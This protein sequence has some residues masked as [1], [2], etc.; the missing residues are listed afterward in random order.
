MNGFYVTPSIARK[1]NK[2]IN[3]FVEFSMRY[4]NLTEIQNGNTGQFYTPMLSY[5]IGN[6]YVSKIFFGEYFYRL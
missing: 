4:E 1:L 6:D 2:D 5:V 3:T